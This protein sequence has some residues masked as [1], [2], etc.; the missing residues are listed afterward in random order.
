LGRAGIV[1]ALIVG[2]AA[3]PDALGS[4]SPEALSK[5]AGGQCVYVNCGQTN[6]CVPWPGGPYR[7]YY[8]K[9]GYYAYASQGGGTGNWDC[10]EVERHANSTCTD[11]TG[12]WGLESYTTDGCP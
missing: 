7:K 6:S 9:L 10:I 11:K 3:L 1:G 4:P 5:A 8:Y 2:V 12:T